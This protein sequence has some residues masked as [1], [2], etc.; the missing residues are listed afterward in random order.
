MDGCCCCSKSA[1]IIIQEN[2]Q[3]SFK[4]IVK[5]NSN[6]AKVLTKRFHLNGHTVEFHR[7]TEMSQR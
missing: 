7:Q 6:H 3:N 1:K 4:K 2:F 5:N